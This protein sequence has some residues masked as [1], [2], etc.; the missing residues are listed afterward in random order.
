MTGA[1]PP[2]S[3]LVRPWTPVLIRIT[4]SGPALPTGGGR[5]R[6]NNPCGKAR[7]PEADRA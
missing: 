1:T 3:C 6:H 5:S 7:I 4:G 2:K